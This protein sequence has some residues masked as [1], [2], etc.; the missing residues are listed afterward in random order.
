MNALKFHWSNPKF[1][2][3]PWPADQKKPTAKRANR[4]RCV[5][6][7]FSLDGARAETARL[8]DES[9]SFLWKFKFCGICSGFHVHRG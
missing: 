8:R 1:A 3:L 6:K 2:G 9:P 7:N 5:K 4:P